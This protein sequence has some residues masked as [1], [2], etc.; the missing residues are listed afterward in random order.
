MPFA[1]AAG[2]PAARTRY[3]DRIECNAARALFRIGHERGLTCSD[4]QQRRHMLYWL[5]VLIDCEM[6]STPYHY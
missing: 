4:S 1:R 5:G 3:V 6:F 2:E